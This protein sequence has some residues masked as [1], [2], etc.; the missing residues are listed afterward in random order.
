MDKICIDTD[1]YPYFK[2]HKSKRDCRGAFYF[3][4]PRWQALKHENANV[5]LKQHSR[6]QSV[7]RRRKH[8]PGKI[9]V[10]ATYHIIFE[11][12]KEYGYQGLDLG[13]KVHFLL[14]GICCD[15]ELYTS[16]AAY[17]LTIQFRQ[18]VAKVAKVGPRKLSFTGIWLSFTYSLVLQ[19]PRS[20]EELTT[21]FDA[22]LRSAAYRK[23][24]NRSHRRS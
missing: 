20:F 18:Q 13:L 10:L 19:S 16:I 4:H 2:Q 1:L 24:P 7:I 6:H 5:M 8:G 17:N 23:L 21:R 12:L 14:N 9:C 11:N 15:K 3:I 22:T